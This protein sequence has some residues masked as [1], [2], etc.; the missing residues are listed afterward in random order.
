MLTVCV[1]TI[2]CC[3]LVPVKMLP[4][5]VNVLPRECT[6]FQLGSVGSTVMNSTFGHSWFV[7]A[8]LCAPYKRNPQISLL[9]PGHVI[10]NYFS[11]LLNVLC[12]KQQIILAFCIFWRLINRHWFSLFV[13]KCKS[14]LQFLLL[15]LTYAFTTHE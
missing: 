15:L 4:Y 11:F 7:P 9:E 6:T 1:N 13:P 12:F 2:Q 14:V 5:N 8:D 10:L 3:T